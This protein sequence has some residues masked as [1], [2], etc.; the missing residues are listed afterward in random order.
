MTA[1]TLFGRVVIR[2]E[3]CS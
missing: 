3:A 1:Y 2:K